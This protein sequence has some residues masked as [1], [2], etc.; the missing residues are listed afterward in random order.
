MCKYLNIN[1]IYSNNS[2]QRTLETYVN[3]SS[4]N[5]AN[6]NNSDSKLSNHVATFDPGT[7]NDIL[8]TVQ[9]R[10]LSVAHYENLDS[11]IHSDPIEL[12][13]VNVF[14]LIMTPI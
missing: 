6:S 2:Q 11:Q 3:S 12:P 14:A 13:S 9:N 1:R 4:N 8:K 5:T 7:V 10:A